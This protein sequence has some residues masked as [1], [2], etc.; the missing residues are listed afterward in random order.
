MVCCCSLAGTKACLSCPTY[1]NDIAFG[2]NKVNES[3]KY[4][5][6]EK[7]DENGKLIERITE[8]I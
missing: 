2:V 8:N 3:Y 4:R 6:V 1:L 5:V 7:F